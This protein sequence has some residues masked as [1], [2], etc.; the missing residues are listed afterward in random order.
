[1]IIQV[2][3][4]IDMIFGVEWVFDRFNVCLLNEEIL[5]DVFF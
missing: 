4:Y 5:Y 2:L 3:L 1:M